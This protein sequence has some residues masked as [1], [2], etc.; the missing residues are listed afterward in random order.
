M[1]FA[2][3]WMLLALMAVPVA[4]VAHRRL[5]RRREARR[6]VLAELGLVAPQPRPG[7][8]RVVVTSLFLSAVALLAVA[9]ARP[10]ATVAEPRREGTVVLAFDVSTSMAAKDLKPTRLEAAKQAARSFV[11]QQPGSIRLAVVAFGESGLVAQQPTLDR[12]QVLA[13]IDR[14]QPQGGTSVGRGILT[15]LSAIAGRAVT[16]PTSSETGGPSDDGLGYYGSAAVVLLS[17]GENTDD[18]DPRELADLASSA[19]V[20]IYPIGLGSPRGTVLQV[21]GFMIATELHEDVL[22]QIAQTT[23]G[24]YFS[25][26][27]TAGLTKVYDSI[28][29]TWTA[30]AEQREVTSLFATAAVLLLLLGAGA[31]ILW[32][33][34][35]V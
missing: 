22:R 6:S 15:S 24:R 16:A 12:G 13:A 23:N 28:D 18:P 33:G 34:R 3:P 2:W 26:A 25:A 27:D 31:S 19:G 11:H 5:G 4:A 14:L 10:Q 17:D 29:L 32:F 21:D 35:V 20:R 9:M 30:H 7:R 8:R 1:T